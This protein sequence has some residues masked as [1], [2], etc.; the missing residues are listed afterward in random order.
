MSL[1]RTWSNQLG[2][3]R[4]CNPST[5]FMPVVAASKRNCDLHE[6]EMCLP[7]V[8]AKGSIY[9]IHSSFPNWVVSW[10]SSKTTKSIHFTRMQCVWGILR[11]TERTPNLG[12]C[13]W[14]RFPIGHIFC[15]QTGI[16]RSKR[17]TKNA[18]LK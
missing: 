8:T 18:P 16:P 4:L 10:A 2:V 6:K 17:Q 7:L 5:T 9:E 1:H 13:L 3:M 12:S 14:F 11:Q 15:Q